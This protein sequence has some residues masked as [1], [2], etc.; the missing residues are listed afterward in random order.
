MEILLLKIKEDGQVTSTEFKL[1]QRLL[2]EYERETSLK[3]AIRPMDIKKMSRKWQKK[4]ILGTA[5]EYITPRDYSEVSTNNELN[6]CCCPVIY[7]LNRKFK[8]NNEQNIIIPSALPPYD[9]VACE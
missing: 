4:G 3:T 2:K 8:D 6:L 5:G 7:T 9:I 1:F